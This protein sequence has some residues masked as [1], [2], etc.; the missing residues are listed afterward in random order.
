M[1]DPAGPAVLAT[2]R[3]SGAVIEPVMVD[4]TTGRRLDPRDI[5]LV[6]GPS[7][8][9]EVRGRIARAD[10]ARAARHGSKTSSQVNPT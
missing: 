7:A 3:E 4:A 8:G 5:R 6:E 2:D 1:A 9:P 10:A